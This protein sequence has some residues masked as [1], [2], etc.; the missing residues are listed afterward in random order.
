VSKWVSENETLGRNAIT[1]ANR[2][3]WIFIGVESLQVTVLT[4]GSQYACLH[5][6]AATLM[7]A[8]PLK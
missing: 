7:F 1:N 5:I 2:I 3:N 8:I 6:T 4:L